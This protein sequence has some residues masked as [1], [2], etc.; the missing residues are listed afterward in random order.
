MLFHVIFIIV[1]EVI[2]SSHGALRG[3]LL[4]QGLEVA[5]VLSTLVPAGAARPPLRP[6]AGGILRRTA[7]VL[8]G[9]ILLDLEVL[10]VFQQQP[11]ARGLKN[12][13]KWISSPSTETRSF[14]L[15]RP[16]SPWFSLQFQLKTLVNAGE[17]R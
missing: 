11:R 6:A 17:R 12:D 14:K 5:L 10:L 3:G 8:L 13:Q 1:F 4:V 15:K 16:R 9:R 2:L 7:R